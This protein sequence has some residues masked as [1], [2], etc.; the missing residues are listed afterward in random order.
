MVG[1]GNF[2]P[3]IRH[4]DLGGG[5]EILDTVRSWMVEG[6]FGGRHLRDF[7]HWRRSRAARLGTPCQGF[8][9]PATGPRARGKV[10]R[11]V[12]A[13]NDLTDDIQRAAFRL[14]VNAAHVLA[15]HAEEE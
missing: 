11:M 7:T 3:L 10:E 14:L 6:G 4:A 1:G 9:F 2:K 12:F 5:R 13:A 8:F 15:N